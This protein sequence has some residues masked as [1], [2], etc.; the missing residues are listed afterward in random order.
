MLEHIFRNID[1]IRIFDVMTEF[2]SSD[3]TLDID[4][5]MDMLEYPEYKRVHVKDSL[6]YLVRQHILSIA[7]KK[8]EGKT[9]CNICKHL[10]KLN[11]PRMGEHK[12]HISE[13]INIGFINEYYMKDNP[14][15]QSLINAIYAHVFI[16][17]GLE[18]YVKDVVVVGTTKDGII[19]EE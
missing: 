3:C 18:E 12:T 5:I 14:I 10:D 9:G 13:Q 1:D 2:V 16:S 4:E 11:I 17:E 6:D 15:T 19:N 7:E 8:E